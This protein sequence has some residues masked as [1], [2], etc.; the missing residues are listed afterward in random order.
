MSMFGDN[1]TLSTA[2]AID[3]IATAVPISNDNVATSSN[4]A[5]D[6][7]ALI[8][9]LINNLEWIDDN[10]DGLANNW[11][12]N[13][14]TPTISSLAQRV[15]AKWEV[16]IDEFRAKIQRNHS[17]IVDIP[18]T[19]QIV[20]AST[21]NLILKE[22]G[23]II[24]TLSADEFGEAEISFIANGSSLTLELE[25]PTSVDDYFQ[26]YEL[27]YFVQQTD[28]VTAELSFI[29]SNIAIN[30]SFNQDN[31]ATSSSVA[32]DNVASALGSGVD[33]IEITSQEE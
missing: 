9:I 16:G 26:V 32:T 1:I 14:G 11:I 6:N 25:D 5:I 17:A 12:L 29:E 13:Y 33:N 2:V 30:N 8:N 4:V 24:A 20:Y 27:Q 10:S 7:V 3:N 21:K 28:N 23:T 22:S 31:V 18:T 19:L 15:N